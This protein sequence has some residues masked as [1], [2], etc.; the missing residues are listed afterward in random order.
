MSSH[1]DPCG[2]MWPEIGGMLH[3]AQD[4]EH[5]FLHAIKF[6]TGSAS[7]RLLG[8]VLL[9]MFQPVSASIVYSIFSAQHICVNL[10]DVKKT[11]FF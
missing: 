4:T 6:A 7:D 11:A 3:V 10:Q 5:W 9:L 1:V 8:A 2:L